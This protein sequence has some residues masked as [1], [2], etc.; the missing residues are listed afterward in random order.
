M[1][2]LFRFDTLELTTRRLKKNI[3]ADV[4]ATVWELAK[5]GR[6][7]DPHGLTKPEFERAACLVSFGIHENVASLKPR[8]ASNGA[9]PPNGTAAE[10]KI[11]KRLGYARAGMF[12]KFEAFDVAPKEAPLVHGVSRSDARRSSTELSNTG[13]RVEN[14]QN[15]GPNDGRL[16]SP[17]LSAARPLVA[18]ITLDVPVSTRKESQSKKSAKSAKSAR[19]SGDAGDAEDAFFFSASDDDARADHSASTWEARFPVDPAEDST[20]KAAREPEKAKTPSAPS[21]PADPFADLVA[22][23]SADTSPPTRRDASASIAPKDERS[24]IADRGSS[25]N[26]QMPHLLDEFPGPRASVSLDLTRLGL[27]DSSNG[28]AKDPEDPATGLESARRS[29]RASPETTPTL[30]PTFPP[31]SASP[32]FDPAFETLRG[33]EAF[34]FDFSGPPPFGAAAD[35]TADLKSAVQGVGKDD[36]AIASRARARAHET[37]E[38]DETDETFGV[39]PDPEETP[40]F[41]SEKFSGGFLD[42]DGGVDPPASTSDAPRP[43]RDPEM[44]EWS[45]ACRAWPW[46]ADEARTEERRDE[47]QAEAEAGWAAF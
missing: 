38:T 3:T 24:R 37:D 11:A 4:L 32:A 6:K 8:S 12:W 33:S 13:Q 18:P 1:G 29:P 7:G 40:F 19:A 10:R 28:P 47:K 43:A 31:R 34:A 17:T 30:T 39:E 23:I 27:A 22:A 42:D 20:T 9:P 36:V 14:A 2:F 41:F 26:A 21:S 15:G 16:V 5:S 44:E 46:L 25:R 45:A 35:A